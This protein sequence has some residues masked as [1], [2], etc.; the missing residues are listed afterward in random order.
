MLEAIPDPA[1]L[2]FV[3]TGAL[4]AG[5]TTGFA[6][7]GTGLVAAGFWF[8]ALPPTMVPPMA[9]LTAVVAQLVGLATVRRAFEWGRAAP[10]LLGGTLGV[11]VGVVVLSL[12]SPETLR[13]SVGL[14]LAGYAGFQLLGLARFSIG[15]W[16]GRAADGTV[17]IA[18]G[19]LGGFAGLSGPLPL[20]WLQMRGG[21]SMRQRAT[22][23]PFNLVVLALASLGMALSGTLDSAVLTVAALCLPVTLAGA[24]LGARAY[25]GVSEATFQ[26]VVLVL[27][28]G[29]GAI[30][31]A[32]SIG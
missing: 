31:V 18:G 27:L 8:H 19:F 1:S 10:F 6:G 11:P 5:F 3:L 14:F 17:G 26:Q 24:W 16:G 22:Y 7:F 25:T 4:L 29:S 13:L 30:L 21:P 2:A 20:I 15:E 23:Q 12:T 9:A 32:Q 28:L